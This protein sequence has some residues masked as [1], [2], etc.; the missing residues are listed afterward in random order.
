[1]FLTSKAVY[2]IKLCYKLC[3]QLAMILHCWV[4]EVIHVNVDLKH[5]FVDFN[6]Y[7]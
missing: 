2:S 5:I 7:N 6:K 1:M 4:F 3:N